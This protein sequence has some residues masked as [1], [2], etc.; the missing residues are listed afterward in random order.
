MEYGDDY[1]FEVSTED[2][3]PNNTYEKKIWSFVNDVNNSSYSSNQIIFD[4]SSLYNQSSHIAWNE[5]YIQ[6]PLVSYVSYTTAANTGYVE[7]TKVPN[8]YCLK[9]GYQ[10]LINSVQLE[11]SNSTVQ[12][13]ANN[14]N[15]YNNFKVLTSKSKDWYNTEGPV[16]GYYD[17]DSSNSWKFNLSNTATEYGVGIANNKPGFDLQKVAQNEFRNESSFNRCNELSIVDTN[18]ITI[19]NAKQQAANLRERFST[20]AI[21]NNGNGINLY[22]HTVIIK[23]ADLCDFT[24]KLGLA[25]C[26]MRLIINVNVGSLQIPVSDNAILGVPTNSTFSFNTCPFNINNTLTALFNPIV[27]TDNLQAGILYAGC[28]IR[29]VKTTG[30]NNVE[31]N[32]SLSACRF[33][34][35]VIQLNPEK[36]K[37]Y[38]MNNSQRL[39]V[40]NDVFSTSL[41]NQSSGAQINYVVSNGINN[42]QGVL[43]VPFIA[44]TFNGANA[45]VGGF[46]PALSPY[47]S[48]P[49]TTSPVG[50]YNFNIILAGQPVMPSNLIYN[51]NNYLEQFKGVNALNGGIDGMLTSGNISYYDWS[52][53]YRYHYVDCSRKR[54]D[55]NIPKSV[56]I[57]ATNNNACAIDLFIFVIFERRAMMDVVSGQLELL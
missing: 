2:Q 37:L 36:E 12:Q 44:S 9:N 45:G 23:L 40:W 32:H 43:V 3:T 5:A 29:S 53:N 50:L 38:R 35:P 8:I 6:I 46:S 39:I 20:N 56:S 4:L 25:R 49:S 24:K 48:E 21:L 52:N 1:Q 10:N 19:A 31:Y 15:Y 57:S 47:A 14:I 11:V 7:L 22:Y 18:L 41:Y 30:A 26:Y 55:E 42:I 51:Y 16:M 33:Y 17:K 28:G 54:S 27:I 13:I 34:A